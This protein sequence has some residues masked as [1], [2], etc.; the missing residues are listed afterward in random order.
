M[1]LPAGVAFVGLPFLGYGILSGCL[2]CDTA[3]LIE[4]KVCLCKAGKDKD[5]YGQHASSSLYGHDGSQLHA[6]GPAGQYQVC[7]G[8]HT[9]YHIPWAVTCTLEFELWAIPAYGGQPCKMFSR[10]P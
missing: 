4:Y 1:T 3:T 5:T 7:S 10:C 2:I 8:S 6:A 9:P